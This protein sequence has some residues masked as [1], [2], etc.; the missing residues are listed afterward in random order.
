MVVA[1]GFLLFMV[2]ILIMVYEKGTPM[3]HTEVEE[4]HRATQPSRGRRATRW[5]ARPRPIVAASKRLGAPPAPARPG[6]LAAAPGAHLDL[7]QWSRTG[8]W[9][10]T[11]HP[12]TLAFP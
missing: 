11:S 10:P 4:Q 7:A 1:L 9:R 8:C 12:P 6:A 5:T 3:S 2:G